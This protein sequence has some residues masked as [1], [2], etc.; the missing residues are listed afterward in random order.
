MTDVKEYLQ[1]LGLNSYQAS[2]LTALFENPESDAKLLSVESGVPY[3]KIYETLDALEH[4]NLVNHTLGKP[5]IYSSKGP[6]AVVDILLKEEVEK[7]ESLKMCQ[8]NI[9]DSLSPTLKENKAHELKSTIQLLR[10]EKACWGAFLENMKS[11][12]KS[13]V[14]ISTSKLLQSMLMYPGNIEAFYDATK[15]GIVVKRIY[16]SDFGFK[17]VWEAVSQAGFTKIPQKLY[18]VQKAFGSSNVVVKKLPAGELYNDF[19]IFDNKVLALPFK[20]E[21]GLMQNGLI[22]EDKVMIK[23]Y[24]ECF[25]LFWKKTEFMEEGWC[26]GLKPK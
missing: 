22:I 9:L 17:K 25:D 11:V 13:L 7:I 19:V 6:K 20:D 10:G 1:R 5:K 2:T 18:K 21:N 16:P 4:N 14:G 3:T 26:R 12:K 15:R 8:Q 24:L 23:A